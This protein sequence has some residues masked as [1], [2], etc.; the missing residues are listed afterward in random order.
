MYSAV[1]RKFSHFIARNL[2]QKAL[3]SFRFTAEEKHFKFITIKLRSHKL[4]MYFIIDH[5][6]KTENKMLLL[7]HENILF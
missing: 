3:E 6:F 5:Y 1:N 7:T 4:T 2:L